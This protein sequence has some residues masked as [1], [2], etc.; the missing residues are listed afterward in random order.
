MKIASQ[1]TFKENGKDAIDWRFRS[2]RRAYTIHPQAFNQNNSPSDIEHFQT[3]AP[4]W[5]RHIPASAASWYALNVGFSVS[6]ILLVLFVV[7][8]ISW[9]TS[10]K[11]RDFANRVL[12]RGE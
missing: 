12:L 11:N 7:F 1:W 3:P 5:F 4:T 8:L 9:M 10:S 6:Q 2:C